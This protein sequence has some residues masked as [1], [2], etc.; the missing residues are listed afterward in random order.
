MFG[1]RKLR[2]IVKS[3]SRCLT[4]GKVSVEPEYAFF[5]KSTGLPEWVPNE[6][7][8]EFDCVM[9]MLSSL[10]SEVLDVQREISYLRMGR[11]GG[12][13]PLDAENKSTQVD[14]SSL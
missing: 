5:T 6:E 13:R 8:S 11:M 12:L 7:H 10:R 9:H 1:D 14:N 2:T 4:C 3:G